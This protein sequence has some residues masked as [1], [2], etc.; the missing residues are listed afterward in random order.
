MNEKDKPK[1][2]VESLGF[3]KYTCLNE[4]C[5]HE[6]VDE[7]YRVSDANGLT[8]NRTLGTS[9]CPN[10]GGSRLVKVKKEK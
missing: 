8:F 1:M 10:C 6:F 5:H 4:H 2:E 3:Y 9:Y 7:L